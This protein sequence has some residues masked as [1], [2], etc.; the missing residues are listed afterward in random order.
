MPQMD[1]LD[2]LKRIRSQNKEVPVIMV[3][4]EDDSG[5][6]RSAAQFG[7]SCFLSKPFD[8]NE[9][10]KQV[11]LG[12]IKSRLHRINEHLV[13]VLGDVVLGLQLQSNPASSNDPVKSQQAMKELMQEAEWLLQYRD[14]A[15]KDLAG[16]SF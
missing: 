16:V 10:Q 7:V 14:Q 4:G 12:I 8:F 3:S 2:C 5:L 11:G 13:R 9:F 1:G 15:A 6:V